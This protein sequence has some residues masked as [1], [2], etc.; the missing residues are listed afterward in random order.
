MSEP[1]KQP[2]N[3]H[4]EERKRMKEF[5]S[6]YQLTFLPIAVAA[7]LGLIVGVILSANLV[8]GR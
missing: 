8:P 3:D 4:E 2:E 1:L 5:I 6:Q 7:I